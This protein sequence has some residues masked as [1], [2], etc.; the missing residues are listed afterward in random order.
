MRSGEDWLRLDKTLFLLQGRCPY[1]DGARHEVIDE[2]VEAGLPAEMLGLQARTSL[3]VPA[4]DPKFLPM[5]IG[6]EPV[7][8]LLLVS[9]TDVARDGLANHRTLPLRTDCLHLF[10]SRNPKDG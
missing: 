5:F 3:R 4:T 8:G 7:V 10:S 9:T 1:S 6:D 2:L